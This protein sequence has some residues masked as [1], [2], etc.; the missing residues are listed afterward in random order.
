MSGS[1]F[2][3]VRW[4]FPNTYLSAVY[5]GIPQREIKPKHVEKSTNIVSWKFCATKTFE[6][7]AGR[8]KL[9]LTVMKHIKVSLCSQNP[10][11]STLRSTVYSNWF[12]WPFCPKQLTN[13]SPKAGSCQGANLGTRAGIMSFQQ[14]PRN[15][16]CVKRV[17]IFEM[18]WTSNCS[19][20]YK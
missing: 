10:I 17:T 18:L 9:I 4:H 1:Y 20:K 5:K 7:R 19:G 14:V 11:S 6:H 8:C 15:H 3:T 16:H 13:D 12:I 2:L